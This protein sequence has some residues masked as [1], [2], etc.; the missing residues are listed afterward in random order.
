VNN[1]MKIAMAGSCKCGK[2]TFELA[3]VPRVRLVCHCT[4]CQAF[5]GKAVSDVMV[6]L[7]SRA[8][9]IGADNIK[10]ESYKKF[11]LPPPNLRRGR[12]TTCLQPVVEIGGVWPMHIFFV[13]VANFER[14]ETLSLPEAHLF[15]EHRQHDVNDGIPKYEG[16]LDSQM[17][18]AKMIYHAM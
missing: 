3:A 10:F 5:T 7:A 11:R 18:V 4:I 1:K 17:A 8:K 2:C 15:Y 13:P 6:V 12:C 16:Y 9:L 14:P